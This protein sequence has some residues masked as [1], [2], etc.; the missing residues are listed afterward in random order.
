MYVIKK[1]LKPFPDGRR[2]ALVLGYIKNEHDPK[3]TDEDSAYIVDGNFVVSKKG[4]FVW[5]EELSNMFGHDFVVKMQV[6]EVLENEGGCPMRTL[7]GRDCGRCIAQKNCGN[8]L[9]IAK[10]IDISNLNLKS[11]QLKHIKTKLK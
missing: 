9:E 7:L 5:N 6:L 10:S 1:S 2:I 11:K 3:S 4:C 8:I